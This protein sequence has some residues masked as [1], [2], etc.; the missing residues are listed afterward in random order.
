MAER[1]PR[2]AVRAVILH[3]GRVLLVNAWPGDQSPLWC[4]PGGGV[5]RGEALPDALAREVYEECGLRV[6]V[7]A[8][9]LVNEYAEAASD[10]HQVEVFFRCEVVEGDLEGAWLDPEGVVHSRR[11]VTRDEIA[12]MTVKPDSLRHVPWEDGLSYDPMEP[13]AR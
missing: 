3:Q 2:L 7:G 10:F 12:E 6:Q 11:W 4:A 13:L 8:P 5:R 1:S 9:C